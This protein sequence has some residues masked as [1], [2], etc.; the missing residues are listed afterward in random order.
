MRTFVS[1]TLGHLPE[2]V[3]RLARGESRDEVARAV[4]AALLRSLPCRRVEVLQPTGGEPV[5]LFSSMSVVATSLE[6][7]SGWG[8]GSRPSIGE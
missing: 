8:S 7:Q 3:E 6:P 4:G 1:V 2:L 5:V